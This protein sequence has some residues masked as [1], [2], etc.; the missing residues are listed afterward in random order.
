MQTEAPVWGDDEG[1]D[2]H[3]GEPEREILHRLHHAIWHEHDIKSIERGVIIGTNTGIA[4][5]DAQG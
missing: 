4:S 2:E 1:R 3:G 5:E